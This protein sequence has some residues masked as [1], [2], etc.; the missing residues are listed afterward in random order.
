MKVLEKTRYKSGRLI[1]CSPDGSCP[2]EVLCEFWSESREKCQWP[3]K[4]EQ[5]KEKM[6]IP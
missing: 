3:D 2:L 6:D 5:D 4:Q 1:K